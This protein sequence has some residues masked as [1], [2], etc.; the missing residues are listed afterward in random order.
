[1]LCGTEH[2]PDVP[3]PYHQICRL[4]AGNSLE[5][6]DPI[7]KIVRWRIRVGKT[8]PLVDGMHQMRAVGFAV[9][10][11]PRRESRHN[12]RLPIVLVQGALPPMPGGP[13]ARSLGGM[14]ILVDRRRV[15]GRSATDCQPKNQNYDR[16]F[17]RIPHGPILML[18]LS[19]VL[20]TLVQR[21][22]R[23]RAR[24]TSRSLPARSI[25][26]NPGQPWWTILATPL[27]FPAA[28]L[29]KRQSSRTYVVPEQE[30]C[31]FV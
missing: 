8:S 24:T 10:M 21:L 12:N 20:V 29:S 28:C 1:M 23:N 19:T 2:N 30:S 3:V 7:V 11:F 27:F 13:A 25:D 16:D 9:S 5:P 14:G 26:E 6:L 22:I 31:R 15:L 18:I 4:R 17:S